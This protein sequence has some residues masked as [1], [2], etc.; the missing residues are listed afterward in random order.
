[1]ATENEIERLKGE[2]KEKVG[3][4]TNNPS[5]ENEGRTD[6]TSAKTKETVDDAADKVT[7]TVDSIKD[8]FNKKD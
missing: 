8:K 3:E 2:A 4:T 1:M 5:L 6:Q 7:D